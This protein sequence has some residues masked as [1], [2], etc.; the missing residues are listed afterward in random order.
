ML[1][2][3]SI[4]PSGSDK[5]WNEIS[6]NDDI[7]DKLITIFMHLIYYAIEF[8]S[9]LFDSY[10]VVVLIYILWPNVSLSSPQGYAMKLCLEKVQSKT[11]AKKPMFLESV[12]IIFFHLLLGF[13]SGL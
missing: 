1:P 8:Q 6:L 12:L 4:H 7:Y 9:M 13:A 10:S 3:Y 2:A 11:R 5:L